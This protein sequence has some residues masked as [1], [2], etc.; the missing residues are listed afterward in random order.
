MLLS[1]RDTAAR[2][3]SR[4][5]DTETERTVR[6]KEHVLKATVVRENCFE[7]LVDELSREPDALLRMSQG[8]MSR[9]LD[10]REGSPLPPWRMVFQSNWHH[11]ESK[12]VHLHLD[13]E[14]LPQSLQS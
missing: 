3:S 2:R 12:R 4:N 5:Q 9:S 6:T 7:T 10:L 1:A 8:T 13:T 14:G 11:S